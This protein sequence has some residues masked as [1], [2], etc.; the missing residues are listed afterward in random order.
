MSGNA[1]WIGIY[2]LYIR[3]RGNNSNNVAR[4]SAG[5]GRGSALKF[6]VKFP[7]FV[8]LMLESGLSGFRCKKS[9]IE[10]R[11]DGG[12]EDFIN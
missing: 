5:I 7:N 9:K 6:A 8:I 10:S 12:D 3:S 11:V 1:N 4:Y 2:S